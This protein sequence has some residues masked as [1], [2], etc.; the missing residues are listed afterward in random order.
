MMMRLVFCCC[1]LCA[2]GV[3]VCEREY[4]W[5]GESI[6]FGISDRSW[7][8]SLLPLHFLDVFGAGGGGFFARDR[9]V[10]LGHYA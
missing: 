6:I 7:L 1:G 2:L 9:H 5:S 4:E 3:H 10:M 8:P